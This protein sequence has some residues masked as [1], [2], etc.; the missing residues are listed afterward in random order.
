MLAVD[1]QHLDFR[2]LGGSGHGG[3]AGS[4]QKKHRS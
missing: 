4:Q 1:N 2:G 3:A